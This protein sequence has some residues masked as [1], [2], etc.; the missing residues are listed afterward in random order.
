VFDQL[1]QSPDSA[2]TA[3]SERGLQGE[4]ALSGPPPNL[5]G[6]LVVL[7]SELR[8]AAALLAERCAARGADPRSSLVC[9]S[10]GSRARLAEELQRCATTT[11]A[12]ARPRRSPPSPSHPRPE[13][14]HAGPRPRRR[15]HHRQGDRRVLPRPSAPHRRSPRGHIIH[16]GLIH[17]GPGVGPA[18]GAVRD[19]RRGCSLST[20]DEAKGRSR[21]VSFQT[22]PLNEGSPRPR[23]AR[24]ASPA[25]AAGSPTPPLSRPRLIRWRPTR[26]AA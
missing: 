7:A 21:R 5:T 26:G 15:G 17:N 18:R 8:A 23:E 6:S 3:K 14:G 12:C 20:R 22:T 19:L 11:A 16:N 2:I 13:R 4:I 24:A 10:G 1:V 9:A 25:A